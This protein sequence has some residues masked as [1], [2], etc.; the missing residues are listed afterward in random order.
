MEQDPAIEEKS[1]KSCV[2]NGT[3][4]RGGCCMRRDTSGDTNAVRFHI[5]VESKTQTN[6]Q[7]RNRLT[8]RED[9]DR[10]PMG[11]RVLRGDGE[12]RGKDE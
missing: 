1:M 4:E 11:G 9:S 2:C 12:K 10:C 3:D 8:D 7:N 5:H 6:K